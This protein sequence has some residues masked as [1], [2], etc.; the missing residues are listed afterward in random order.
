MHSR[1]AEHAP[2]TLASAAYSRLRDEII[3]TEIAP[4]TRLRTRQLCARYEMGLSPIREALS[5]LSSEGL[6]VQSDQ[7]GFTV[8]PL[9]A[10]DLAELTRTRTWLNETGLRESIAH[11]GQDWEEALLLAFHRLSRIP[12]FGE[13]IGPR[14]PAW[15]AAHR[16]FHRC[17]IAGCRS[18]WLLGFC[19]QLFDAF[20]RY[21]NLSAFTPRTRPDHVG[22]HEAL[23]RAALARRAEEAAQLL[24]AHF[25]LSA[26]LALGHLPPEVPPARP[27]GERG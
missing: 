6:V 4:G 10:A 26:E 21:R 20:E 2:G 7:R 1:A 12:R 24:R 13:G 14:N 25:A 15:D 18:G 5:R 11:G 8:A 27:R 3:S 16:H 19:D 9:S 23:T 22:E 17:L